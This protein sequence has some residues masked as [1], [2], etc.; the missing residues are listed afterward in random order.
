MST[1]FGILTEN[2]PHNNLVDSDGDLYFY[3]SRSI[4][5]PIFFRG[6]ESRWLNVLAQKLTDDTKVYALDN[7]QQGVYTI[8]DCKELIKKYK[9]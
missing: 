8:K 7:T 4:F 2:I 6:N 9:K 1:R 3:I 5:E